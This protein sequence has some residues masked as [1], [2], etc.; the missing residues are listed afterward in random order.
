MSLYD[1]VIAVY[2]L[3]AGR[4]SD[5]IDTAFVYPEFSEQSTYAVGESVS[6]DGKVYKCST[7]IKTPKPWD[8]DDWTEQPRLTAENVPYNS[9]YPAYTVKQ[10]LDD[11][12]TTAQSADAKADSLEKNKRD[13]TE[14]AVFTALPSSWTIEGTRDSS[15]IWSAGE[16]IYD[17]VSHEWK[18]IQAINERVIRAKQGAEGV[19]ELVQDPASVNFVMGEFPYAS[20]QDVLIQSADGGT[21]ATV[22]ISAQASELLP[23]SDTLAKTSQLEQAIAPLKFAAWYPDGS[24]KSEADFTQGLKYGTPDPSTGTVDV[25][26]FAA[27]GNPD[28]DNG[29]IAGRVVVPPFVD[30]D[31]VRYTVTG[32]AGS[33]GAR[34]YNEVLTAVVLPTTVTKIGSSAFQRC[35]S[36]SAVSMPTVKQVE[37]GAFS[38]CTVLTSVATTSV[39][40]VGMS[41]F[42]SCQRLE[43]VEMPLVTDVGESA[44]YYCGDLTSVALPKATSVPDNAFY[45]CE[46]LTSV[47]FG[48]TPRTSV[49]A[50]GSDAFYGVPNTCKIIVPDAQYDEWTAPNE[51]SGADEWSAVKLGAGSTSIDTQG[52]LVYAY[53][54]GD[55]TANGVAFSAAPGEGGI[56]NANCT[57]NITHPASTTPPGDVEEGGYR[58]ILRY[59]WYASEGTRTVSLKNLVAGHKYIVQ[60][61]MSRSD[62]TSQTATVNGATV[63]FGGSG[64]EY[65]GSL[66]GVITAS[67]TTMDISVAYTGNSWLNAIQV[68]DLGESKRNPWY[69]LV[70]RGYKFLRHSEWEAPH[71]YELADKLDKQDVIDPRTA[72]LSDAGKAAD[73]RATREAI[74]GMRDKLD[75]KVYEEEYG[76]ASVI[77]PD[78]YS[79]TDG[80]ETYVAPQGGETIEFFGP[81]PGVD[82]GS[83][84][85]PENYKEA[86][87]FDP[88]AQSVWCLRG[89]DYPEDMMFGVGP[90]YRVD[91]WDSRTPAVY[92]IYGTDS[93]GAASMVRRVEGVRPTED[94]LAAL[95]DIP[96]P[97]TVIPK[98]DKGNGSAGGPSEYPGQYARADHVHPSD[99]SKLDV[100]EGTLH[101]MYSDDWTVLGELPQGMK[102][103]SGPTWR[104]S[105]WILELWSGSAPAL[106]V[107][108]GQPTQT[109]V[110][111]TFY[112]G[113]VTA[114]RDSASVHEMKGY[115]LGKAYGTN[116]DKPLQPAGDYAL[117]ASPA[118]AD[119]LAAL[120]TDGNLKD[121]GKSLDDISQEIQ[122]A[123]GYAVVVEDNLV[124]IDGPGTSVIEAFQSGV[125]AWLS[126]QLP[127]WAS[128]ANLNTAV[129]RNRPV[130]NNYYYNCPDLLNR[131]V[132]W[133][134]DV[135]K[136][137]GQTAG[138]ME[139]SLVFPKAGVYSVDVEYAVGLTYQQAN[140]PRFLVSVGGVTQ[141]VVGTRQTD[142][143]Q[144]GHLIF[145][146]QAG[147]NAIRLT[148]TPDLG[149]SEK[150][151]AVVIASLKVTLVK[152]DILAGQS[153]NLASEPGINAALTAVIEKLGGLVE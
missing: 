84:W 145:N 76:N 114:V 115:R 136:E 55:Y 123:I 5:K 38:G 112:N 25:L 23:T 148:A 7:E 108:D 44:F 88:E 20:A 126:A 12:R 91:N 24:V 113:T 52:T 33:T 125:T 13:K 150:A 69:D 124:P 140:V 147:S 71:R 62:F 87:E 30:I 101:E 116:A 66:V 135:R 152:E 58:E 64:W 107:A 45:G 81:V 104:G 106:I 70:L 16:Y 3:I 18:Y 122:D 36:L 43:Q 144:T 127:S 143:L 138:Y 149:V 32:V 128:N 82:G 59:G 99:T 141:E 129:F 21:T 109:A 19:Y 39:E 42:N 90:T 83:Y 29:D 89:T 118:T 10:A 2:N 98:M 80:N 40:R 34:A 102:Y 8:A 97:S 47:D 72:G 9:E 60:L 6:H 119:N 49:P 131:V 28:D 51:E 93:G 65:G 133:I 17:S 37:Y 67:S 53:A 74:E 153:F 120:D 95:S 56:N 121:S 54:R 134:G 61:V 14:L 27:T 41:A 50:L 110:S 96:R 103:T 73:A 4:I 111:L 35:S 92:I 151:A 142:V 31:G 85:V 100:K 48:D 94:S 146:V 105:N 46:A 1:K 15:T 77:F 68:R 11:A 117:K 79:A 22:R 86:S 57:V 78:G 132:L 139:R 137:E 63:K 26:A 75:L 130:N